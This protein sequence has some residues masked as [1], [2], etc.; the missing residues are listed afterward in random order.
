[1]RLE[2]AGFSRATLGMQVTMYNPNKYGITLKQGD[3]DVY[4]D[5]LLLGK[6]ILNEKSR[7]P[8]RDTF[9]LPLLLSIDV[10]KVLPKSYQLLTAKQIT[11]KLNG[12]MKAGKYGL[13]VRMPV[14]YEGKQNIK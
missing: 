13:Y 2:K 3:I 5:G 4:A 1:M 8:K 6:L 10:L 9:S 11:L 14:L 12:V 7:I